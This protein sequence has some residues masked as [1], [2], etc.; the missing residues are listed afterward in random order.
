MPKSQ[1]VD[2][3]VICRSFPEL[4]QPQITREHI[5]ETIDEY[6]DSGIPAVVMQGAEGVGKTTL[7]A[8][9]SIRHPDQ[10]LSL[11]LKPS[12]RFGYD[13]TVMLFDLCN[14][15]QWATCQ[16]ELKSVQQVSEGWLRIG[17]SDLLA[18]SRRGKYY[19]FVVDGLD[20]IPERELSLEQ[21]ILDM[22]PFGFSGFRFLLSSGREG[23]RVS[24]PK[25]IRHQGYPLEKFTL[26]ETVRYFQDMAL[27]REATEEVFRTFRGVPLQLESVRRIL[28]TEGVASDA[29]LAS[30][31]QKYPDLFA[32]EWDQVR[33]ADDLQQ[34]IL[35][36]LAHDL[37]RHTIGD[38]ARMLNSDP[39]QVESIIRELNFLVVSDSFEVTFVSETF[40][41]L[42]ADRLKHLR[43]RASDLA[44]NDLLRDPDSQA[45]LTLLPHYYRQAGRLEDLLDYLSPDQF[46]RMLELSQSLSAVQQ[47]AD[48]GVTAAVELHRDGDLLRFAMQKA[49]MA[50]LAGIDVW[51]SEVRA[52]MA[53]SDHEAAMAL[54]QSPVMKED[55]LALLAAIAKAMHGKGLSP[56]A[57][58]VEQIHQLYSQIDIEA[59]GELAVD[60]A[61]DLVY[62][63]RA[64]AIEMV[65]RATKSDAGPNALD[66][67]FAKLAITALA[68]RDGQ[69]EQS[70]LHEELQTRIRDPKAKSFSSAVSVLVR[71]SAAAVVLAEVGKLEGTSERLYLLRRWALQNRERNDALD[72]VEYA[73]K[74]AITTTEYAPNARVLREL[75]TPL[76]YASDGPRLRKLVSSFDSQ[77]DAIEQLGPTEDYVRLQLLL[78]RAESKGDVQIARNRL[79]EVYLFVSAVDDLATRTECT[80]R[81][82]ASLTQL[83]PQR[84]LERTEGIHSLAENDLKNNT[85]QLLKNTA[86]HYTVT[87]GIIRALAKARPELAIDLALALNVQPRRDAALVDMVESVVDVPLSMLDLSFTLKIISKIYDPNLRDEAIL[88][89]LVRLNTGT[90]HQQIGLAG[91]R[92]FLDCIAQI[93]NAGQ[94]CNA[95][96]LTYRF[97]RELQLPESDELATQILQYINRAWE[98]IDVGW[99]KVDFGFR[100]AESV[101]EWS[102]ELGRDYI[103]KTDAYRETVLIAA[104]TPAWTYLAIIRLAIRAYSSLLAR[105]ID[106]DEDMR[107][108]SD[109]IELVPSN[110]ER[111]GL[112]SEV[113][114]RSYVYKRQ[115]ECSKIVSEHVRP[116]LQSIPEGD[117]GYRVRVTTVVAPALY[118]AHKVTALAEVAKLPQPHR[119]RAYTQIC[120]FLLGRRIPGE[121]YDSLPGHVYDVSYEDMMD[122]CELIDKMDE[123][124][125]I[126]RYIDAMSDS[127][128]SLRRKGKLS[129]QQELDVVQTLRQMLDRGKLP[130]QRFIQHEGYKIVAQARCEHINPTTPQIWTDLIQAA[131]AIPNISDRSFVLAIV[132]ISLPGKELAR[133]KVLL[134]EALELAAQIPSSLDRSQRYQD[135]ASLLVDV[136]A[137]LARQC[138]RMAMEIATD[139]DDRELYPLQR[140]II[141]LAYRLDPDFAASLAS[142][143]DQDPARVEAGANLGERLRLLDVEKRMA[144]QSLSASEHSEMENS[145]YPRAAW[146]LLGSL[147]SGKIG[148]AGFDY[149]RDF[150]KYAAHLPLREGYP[151]LAWIV[152]NANRRLGKD[153]RSAN[154]LRTL[155]NGVLTMAQL[156]SRLTTQSAVQLREARCRDVA[157]PKGSSVLFLPG[158]R[159]K[160]LQFL[161]DWFE[162]DVHDYLKICDPFFGPEDLEILQLLHT[163]NSGCSV[164]ILTSRKHQNNSGVAAP[165]DEAYRNYW[166]IHL[167]ANQD[168]PD[169]EVAIVGT[170][171]GGELPIHER[172]WLTRGGGLRIGTSFGAL[173]ISRDSE[174]SFLTEEEA[175]KRET[176]E[177]DPLLQRRRRE[178]RGEKLLYNL[179]TL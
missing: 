28:S 121:P 51:R 152:E 148:P 122:I 172:W 100:V 29:F 17:Y 47:T 145:E 19:Y 90:D 164:Q 132:A 8:Q 64:L 91:F 150:A 72:V 37:T 48:L 58:I 155:F 3:T 170:T 86:E 24:L 123:D 120:D 103:G 143:A 88:K 7:L 63:D 14:Q 15:I 154:Y 179:F 80:A 83:D 124:A 27:S 135:L 92:P 112:W 30:L 4:R 139:T 25:G 138:L 75:A 36:I 70:D 142:L 94:R 2:L 55:R 136:E 40:R 38:L 9:F 46:A 171:S 42:A 76:A 54:A 95:Y 131:R 165:W 20:E 178:H 6:F 106:T 84:Q 68:A 126:Y 111:A 97:L 57:E 109:L 144:D 21:Q 147:N 117:L 163:V 31:P 177:V 69:P 65:E 12:S 134:N 130:S 108:I 102:S 23:L 53:V 1:I 93:Q 45:A 81:L 50:E 10:A 71:D 77:K 87:R 32:L 18:R 153:D 174:I 127:T 99:Q 176:E 118:C 156:A 67:A 173:G 166:R 16:E 35:A 129:R 151:I 98:A 82:V 13:P 33:S 114:L 74:L 89:V 34:A 115:E 22:L 66:W 167:S 116:L 168:P 52:R 162:H 105:H 158:D 41:R 133:R 61:A 104:S 128:P 60:I 59:W 78:A 44:I 11:F 73:L 175:A 119:D 113:A 5:L 137:P 157:S 149:V 160:A 56:S 101:A 159:E 146:R 39:V 43:T 161:R 169:T 26:D 96:S 110:G 140:R 79:V 141:D 49:T 85:E 62:L 125:T 107:L